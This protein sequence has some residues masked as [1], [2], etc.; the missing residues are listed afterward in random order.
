MIPRYATQWNLRMIRMPEAWAIQK[1]VKP[2]LVA[3]LDSGF[4]V[5]HPDF[6]DEKGQRI[7]VASKL[8]NF[9]DPT[10]PGT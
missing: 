4:D 3:V 1:G 10:N 7:Y 2:V 8:R 5:G 6:E 9:A